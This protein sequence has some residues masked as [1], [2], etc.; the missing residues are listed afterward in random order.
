MEGFKTLI[1]SSKFPWAQERISWKFIDNLGMH[2]QKGSPALVCTQLTFYKV[3][4][5]MN[6]NTNTDTTAI[7]SASFQISYHTVLRVETI[8]G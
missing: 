4:K 1:C 3:N 5:Q 7:A 6:N 8:L 2:P